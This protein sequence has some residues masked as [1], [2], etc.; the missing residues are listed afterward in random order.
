MFQSYHEPIPNRCLWK[1]CV[2]ETVPNDTREYPFSAAYRDLFF[3]T[4]MSKVCLCSMDI[5]VLYVKCTC[6]FIRCILYLIEDFGDYFEHLNDSVT[7][8]NSLLNGTF[9][10]VVIQGVAAHNRGNRG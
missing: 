6:V 7:A 8:V 1:P 4:G 5:R 2:A 10:T 9:T 3:C